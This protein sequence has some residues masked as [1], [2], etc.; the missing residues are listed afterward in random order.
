MCPKQ[1]RVGKLE[2]N[3]PSFFYCNVYSKEYREKYLGI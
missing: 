3:D 1:M 2:S